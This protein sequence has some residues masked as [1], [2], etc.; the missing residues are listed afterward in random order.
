MEKMLE[1][2]E[3]VV[4]IERRKGEGEGDALRAVTETAIREK[5][6]SRG[7]G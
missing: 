1:F 7:Y 6:L 2:G 3:H 5:S 4:Y